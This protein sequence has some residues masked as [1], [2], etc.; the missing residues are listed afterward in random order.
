MSSCSGAFIH[1]KMSSLAASMRDLLSEQVPS[2]LFHYTANQ[3]KVIRR[4]YELTREAEGGIQLKLLANDLEITPAAASEMVETLVRRG[5]LERRNDLND[6]RAVSLNLSPSWQNKFNLCEKLLENLLDS[7][8]EN[9]SENDREI[10]SRICTE[11][12]DFMEIQ[13]ASRKEKK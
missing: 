3:L 2:D 4:V 7:F 11:L 13:T 6:R 1:K 12:A 5:A 9:I 10:F 8:F